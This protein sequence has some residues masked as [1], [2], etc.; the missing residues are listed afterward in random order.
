MS[1]GGMRRAWSLGGCG[2]ECGWKNVF[3]W[4]FFSPVDEFASERI[5]PGFLFSFKAKFV[6]KTGSYTRQAATAFMRFS[7][8]KSNQCFIKET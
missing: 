6:L 1:S 8:L 4:L 5:F 3:K 7:R 2:A